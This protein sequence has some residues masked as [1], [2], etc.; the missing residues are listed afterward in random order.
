MSIVFP[1]PT[2]LLTLKLPIQVVNGVAA[3]EAKYYKFFKSDFRAVVAS[4]V[5]GIALADSII[6][7]NITDVVMKKNRA[8]L[9]SSIN[10]V[11]LIPVQNSSA[12]TAFSALVTASKSGAFANSLNRKLTGHG[13]PFKVSV[14]APVMTDRNPTSFPTI[15]PSVVSDQM[16]PISGMS[17]TTIG[18]IAG[19]LSMACILFIIFG[20]F[21]FVHCSKMQKRR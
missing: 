15:S 3:R 17:V 8:L 6:I 20:F 2:N 19:F 14:D 21:L 16:H 11:Y 5:G 12:S 9:V 7:M 18:L 13:V 10:V 4:I 1:I